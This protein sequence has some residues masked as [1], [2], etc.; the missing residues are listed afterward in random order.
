MDREI[1]KNEQ[2]RAQRKRIIRLLI[3]IGVIAMVVL[4]IAAMMRT[5]IRRSDL[6]IATVD[7]GA[8]ETS[9]A[10]T[11]KVIPAFE[12][13]INSPIS[14]RIIEVYCK[15]G[16]TVSTGT[17]LLRLDLQ[18]AET[19]IKRLADERRSKQ[20]EME[21]TRLNNHTL[22]SDL[23][24]QVK[25]KELNINRLREEVANERRLDSIGS[26]TGERVRQAEFAYE[27]GRLEL[28]QL[29]EQLINERAVRNASNKMKQLELDI[30][31]KNFS[32]K[33]RTFED[34]RL[35]AP[36]S[37][38][39]TYINDQIGQQV[40]QGQR[41]AI[42]AD[43]S[44]FKVSAEISDTYAD[45]LSIGCRVVVKSGQT[46]HPGMVT[47]INPLTNNGIITF[48]IALDNDEHPL[49][50]SGLKTEVHVLCDIH[51]DAIRI[52]SGSY[53]RGPGQY[54]LFVEENNELHR[55]KV[56]LGDSNYEYVE[57]LSG[58]QPGEK[59]V[60]TDMTEYN[61]NSSLK[62]K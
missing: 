46:E 44:H 43:L 18:S 1:P 6:T 23:E 4:T 15:E 34:A 56:T 61:S 49:L 42:I 30:F 28:E 20:L 5:S 2:R 25:V 14:S 13:I 22:L 47:N 32:E 57:V 3:P 35:T 27:T 31:D 53:F 38:T 50:R 62:I 41:V 54:D 19:E 26:G 52:P 11:G 60:T 48:S 29:R 39:L 17:P 58:L 36:R 45:R 12:Q 51:D 24:M 7:R 55:R 37:A 10:G 8:I 16:D 33:Q 40:S 59:V 21:Q 9:V